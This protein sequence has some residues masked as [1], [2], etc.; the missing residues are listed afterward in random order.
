MKHLLLCAIVIIFVGLTSCKTGNFAAAGGQ[1]EQAY[2]CLVSSDRLANKE[3]QVR[4]DDNTPFKAK[5]Q[6]AKQNTEKHNGQLYGIL[7]G[8]RHVEIS[9]NGQV[10]YSQEVFISSQQ[11]KT[12]NL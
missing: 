7:P 9:Y 10:V 3:V 8:R 2:I 12:I 5:V 6:R 4:I 1:E 11:T